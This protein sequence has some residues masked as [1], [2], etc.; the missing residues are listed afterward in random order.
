MSATKRFTI[1]IVEDEEALREF[2]VDTLL[3]ENFQV[4]SADGGNTAWD[5]LQSHEVDLLVTDSAMP[6]GNGFQL[7]SKLE[8]QGKSLPILVL[9]GYLSLDE[10][11]AKK[12]GATAYLRKPA[13]ADEL[14]SAV[15]AL[16][17]SHAA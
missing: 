7:I 8:K 11:S 6:D 10:N 15:M 4:L 3:A 14:V 5:L 17:H 13:T 2:L 9:S 1:L 12:R 16:L